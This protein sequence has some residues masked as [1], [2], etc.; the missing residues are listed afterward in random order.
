MPYDDC[1]LMPLGRT[2]FI[3]APG[4]P[5]KDMFAF[6]VGKEFYYR[7]GEKTLFGNGYIPLYSGKNTVFAA[8][9]YNRNHRCGIYR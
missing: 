8:K 3:S 5:Q 7:N 4:I 2:E 9:I 1:Y 6:C